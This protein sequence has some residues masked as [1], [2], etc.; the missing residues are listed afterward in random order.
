M[1]SQ[2]I[3]KLAS[4]ILSL[5][6]FWYKALIKYQVA[7][8]IEHMNVLRSVRS[9]LFID[10]GANRGQFSLAAQKAFP[11]A[12]IMCFEPLTS[13][14][15]VLDTIFR[16]KPKVK[17]HHVAIGDAETEMAINVSKREDSSS[18]LDI[19]DSQTK[20]F[21]GTGRRDTEQVTVRRLS[22]FIPGEG[23]LKSIFVKIDVQGYELEVLK[24]ALDIIKGINYFYIE[25]S[26][27]ELYKGQAIASD[28]I[29][30]LSNQGFLLDGIYNLHHDRAGMAVQADCLFINKNL[31]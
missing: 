16:S 24:G 15:K 28:V 13:A 9:E 21:P 23:L 10:I 30:F 5:D 31:R 3:R 22:N 2:K 20:I 26:F 4:I 8:S 12:E 7:P 27:L 1:I 18:L 25:C 11:S 19:L 17:T 14:Y 6:K 29:E